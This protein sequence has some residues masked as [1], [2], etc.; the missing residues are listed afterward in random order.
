MDQQKFGSSGWFVERFEE[1]G[2]TAIK[3]FSHLY[4]K[5]TPYQILDIYDTALGK[6]MVLDGCIMLTEHSEFAYHEMLVHVPVAAHGNVRNVLIIGGGDG[7]AMAELLRHDSIERAVM[8][9]IDKDVV[10]AAREFFPQYVRWI[11]KDSRADLIIDDGAK[12]AAQHKDEFDLIIID[13]TDPV[14]PAASLFT[15]SFYSNIKQALREGG[16][17]VTQAESPWYTMDT[18]KKIMKELASTFEHTAYYTSSIPAYPGG[19]WGFAI[20]SDRDHTFDSP[21]LELSFEDSL[22]YYSKEVHKAAF[23]LPQFLKKAIS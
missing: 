15:E 16:I 23:V 20:A 9:E 11:G 10:D 18:I 19:F 5:V 21:K 6:M 7:G 8:C 13:S 3:I 2:G 22:K 4:H 1:Q 12:F 14:G 17:V